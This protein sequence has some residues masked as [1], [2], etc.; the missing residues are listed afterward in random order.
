MNIEIKNGRVVK[1]NDVFFEVEVDKSTYIIS[2]DN[3]S[4][5]PSLEK[6]IIKDSIISCEIFKD[7][8]LNQ[9]TLLNI[10]SS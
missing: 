6:M 2:Y 9:Y 1:I 4:K 8:K 3:W 5:F 7:K 10:M